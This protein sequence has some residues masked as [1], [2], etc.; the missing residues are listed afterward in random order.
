MKFIY[1][2]I[3]FSTSIHLF[4]QNN[5][6][7]AEQLYAN[8][9][10][11]KAKTQLNLYLE[12]QPNDSQANILLGKVYGQLNQWDLAA[13]TFKNLLNKQPDQADLHY[14]YGAALAM[15][16]KNG[17]KLKALTKL[18]AIEHAFSESLVLNPKHIDA[19]WAFVTYYTELPGI[20]GGSLNKAKSYAKNLVTIS[21]VDGHLA[22]GYIYEYEKNYIEAEKHFVKAHKIG[23][24]KT[25]YKKLYDLYLNKLKNTQKAEQLQVE[26]NSK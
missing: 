6:Q 11:E 25:T 5:T 4:A 17:S 8:K 10:F 13:Q 26:F 22:Y 3:W 14:Y 12:K 16:A 7:W 18:N 20:V 2:L 9:E 23:N 15:Q 21:P 19:H 1:F 24:S